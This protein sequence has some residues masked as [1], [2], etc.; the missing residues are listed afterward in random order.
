MVP[1]LLSLQLYSVLDAMTGKDRTN[2]KA[3]SRWLW[4]ASLYSSLKRSTEEA[5]AISVALRYETLEKSLTSEGTNLQAYTLRVLASHTRG[6]V[7]HGPRQS[8]VAISSEKSSG[9]VARLVSLC[10]SDQLPSHFHVQLKD[11]SPSAVAELLV[12]Q[13]RSTAFVDPDRSQHIDAAAM[14]DVLFPNATCAVLLGTCNDALNVTLA[15]EILETLGNKIQN[16]E[17]HHVDD[18]S[19]AVFSNVVSRGLSLIEKICE[20]DRERRV[21]CSLFYL[22]ASV[23]LVS[24]HSLFDFD[25]WNLQRSTVQLTSFNKSCLL[26]LASELSGAAAE[27]VTSPDVGFDDVSILAAVISQSIAVYRFQLD[28]LQGKC[29]GPVCSASMIALLGQL[30]ETFHTSSQLTETLEFARWCFLSLLSRLCDS[31]AADGETLQALQLSNWNLRAVGSSS[32]E[33]SAWFEATT[34]SLEVLDSPL[35]HNSHHAESSGNTS[36]YEV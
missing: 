28:T 34:M 23:C 36:G 32:L 9:L 27:L 11:F 1:L 22:S 5:F 24:R 18:P 10:V 7:R 30:A 2:R 15:L 8:T 19:V 4:L 13:E 6:I 20:S 3:S 31:F 26:T 33:A 21:I 12:N 35:V 17:P 25:T 16:S 29:A 14:F